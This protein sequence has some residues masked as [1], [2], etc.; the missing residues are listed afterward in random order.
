MERRRLVRCRLRVTVQV[1][2]SPAH[3]RRPL[4]GHHYE[5]PAPGRS[6]RRRGRISVA[7]AS[8]DHQQ[9]RP[10]ASP[11]LE[12]VRSLRLRSWITVRSGKP[13]FNARRRPEAQNLVEIPRGAQETQISL[14]F[15]VGRSSAPRPKRAIE[16]THRHDRRVQAPQS[17]FRLSP[18]P[19]GD[20]AGLSHRYRQTP[21]TPRPR[22]TP[23]PPTT[24]P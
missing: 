1:D 11:E 5:A 8:V 10:A 14:A 9:P 3:T 6:T 18:H 17:P 15:L 22:E 13:L 24:H 4:A 23:P 7:K 20:C 21:R 19:T 16:G 2:D 12:F